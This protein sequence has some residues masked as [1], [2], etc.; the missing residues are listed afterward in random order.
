[1]D[2]P[3][4]AI[5][6]KVANAAF[7]TDVYDWDRVLL[8]SSSEHQ[9]LSHLLLCTGPHPCALSLHGVG[10][11]RGILNVAGSGS[12]ACL[13]TYGCSSI[14][15]QSIQL[16]CKRDV[17]PSKFSTIEVA[18]SLLILSNITIN[19]SWSGSDGGSVKVYAGAMVQV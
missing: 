8:Q 4:A 14:A 5:L 18:G 15:L 12:L 16:N 11:Q 7:F 10:A 13:G 3:K 17:L 9:I 2:V 19:G 1:V 6:P